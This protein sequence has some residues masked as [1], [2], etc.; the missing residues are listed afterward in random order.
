MTSSRL[1]IVAPAPVFSSRKH[2]SSLGIVAPVLV[3]SS[4]KPP[5]PATHRKR[6]IADRLV[7][8]V[9]DLEVVV[10][11]TYV[12]NSQFNTLYASIS[13]AELRESVSA[14]T[15]RLA[16]M[17]QETFVDFEEAV[18]KV[19]TKTAVLD[20]TVHPLTSYVSNYV[21]FL[22]EDQ[23]LRD[24]W[25]LI[26]A[27]D[28]ANRLNVP[29][30]DALNLFDRFL[31]AKARQLG[32]MLR[33]LQQMNHEIEETLHIPFFLFQVSNA[34]VYFLINLIITIGRG[35]TGLSGVLNGSCSWVD[36]LGWQVQPKQ[37]T[38][39]KPENCI[40]HMNRTQVEYSR[41]DMST[42]RSTQF[43]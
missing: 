28:Q 19:A 14:L 25:A 10:I 38:S 37:D 11:V 3:F 7:A 42:S 33:G 15:K 32:F 5:L 27:V 12:C 16:E 18:E 22:F 41:V 29:V 8:D 6:C 23:R 17:A 40:R 2:V 30:A 31:G 20:G 24:N 26:H 39:H 21:K 43:F 34:L 36:E 4:R 9:T 13:A 1:E 35:I